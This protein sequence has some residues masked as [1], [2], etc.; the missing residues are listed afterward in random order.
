MAMEPAR[1]T[2]PAMGRFLVV[3]SLLVLGI[4]T[5]LFLVPG[6]TDTLFSWTVNPPL[7]AGLVPGSPFRRCS[8]S[9]P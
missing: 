2:M 5:P 4:G 7:T 9:P 3:A 1:P 8:C 6:E